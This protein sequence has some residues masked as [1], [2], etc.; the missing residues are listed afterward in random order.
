MECGAEAIA[1]S[2]EFAIASFSVMVIVCLVCFG[3]GKG[4]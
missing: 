3:S 4:M 2:I 1:L